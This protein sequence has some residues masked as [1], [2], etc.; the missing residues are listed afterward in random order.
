M[1]RFKAQSKIC[2]GLA[3]RVVARSY[4]VEGR[5][6]RH[7]E[8]VKGLKTPF[9]MVGGDVDSYLNLRARW[10]STQKPRRWF[11]SWAPPS[12]VDSNPDRVP[13]VD[14]LPTAAAV[15]SGGD[16]PA[17]YRFT[18]CSNY[19]FLCCSRSDLCFDARKTLLACDAPRR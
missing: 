7:H 8:Q 19:V 9:R 10:Y 14:E 17:W 4:V 18:S 12:H 15:K 6:L 16:E 2:S 11:R 3:V 1:I 13:T 5:T